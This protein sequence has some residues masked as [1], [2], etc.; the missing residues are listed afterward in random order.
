MEKEVIV[1]VEKEVVKEVEVIKEVEVEKTG[2]VITG[3]PRSG[4]TLIYGACINPDSVHPHFSFS[5]NCEPTWLSVHESLVERDWSVTSKEIKDKT[6]PSGPIGV[7]AESWD[8]GDDRVTLTFN[9]RKGVKFHDGTDWNAE[10]AEINYRTLIDED[11]DIFN[12]IGAAHVGYQLSHVESIKAVDEFTFQIKLVKPFFGFIDKIASST[13]CAMIS[14]KALLTMTPEEIGEGGPHGTGHFK[15]V[16]WSRGSPVVLER[17]DDYWGEKAL[18]DEIYIVPI[19]DEAS[20]VAALMSGEIDVAADV[21]PDNLILLRNIEG[22]EGYARGVGTFYGLEPNHKEP[23]FSDQQ[24]RRAVSLC[25]DRRVL[26]D[27]LLKGLYDPGAEIWGTTH[28]VNPDGREITDEYD[29]ELA[30]ELLAEAGYPDGFKTKLYGTTGGLSLPTLQVNSFIVISLRECGID[31]EL[32]SFDWLTYL[33]YWTGGI[34]EGENV[35][36][37]TMSMGHPDVAGY[38]QYLHSAA[39]P[40]AGWSMGW[41]ANDQVDLLI[42]KAWNATSREE[43]VQAEREAHDLALDDYAYIPVVNVY[44]NYGVSDRVGG[45]T[46]CADYQ[47]RFNKAFMEYERD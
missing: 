20:R 24:V 40:P 47:C 30:K 41:Y 23:P 45:W 44:I 2:P 36:M 28:A 9:L 3:I 7:L 4:G 26:A 18:L 42:E 21:S 29:P 8:L 14:G 12:S 17:N 13:C 31:V 33:G 46:G 10:V 39:W 37:F 22:I 34:P 32:V 43:Y 1:E 11:S 19:L 16:E 38:D 35:G 5:Y 27:D 6:A 15:F 25:F